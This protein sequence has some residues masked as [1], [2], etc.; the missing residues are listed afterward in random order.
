V[1]RSDSVCSSDTRIARID[2]VLAADF[3]RQALHLSH[4]IFPGC[5]V[6]CNEGLDGGY[7]RYNAIQNE[8]V[9]TR[10]LGSE[11]QG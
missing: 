1:E 10:R 9:C 6:T 4:V 7:E 8:V 11:V 3:T 5:A 2:T